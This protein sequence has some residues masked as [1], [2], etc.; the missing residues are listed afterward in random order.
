VVHRRARPQLVLQPR[1]QDGA[2]VI[3]AM[4]LMLPVSRR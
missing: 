4:Q 2:A 1:L 3:A